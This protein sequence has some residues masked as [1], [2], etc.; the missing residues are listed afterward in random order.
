MDSS[1]AMGGAALDGPSEIRRG[2]EDREDHPILRDDEVVDHRGIGRFEGFGARQLPLRIDDLVGHSRIPEATDAVSEEEHLAVLGVDL[3]MRGHRTHEL[4]AEIECPARFERAPGEFERRIAFFECEQSIA[5]PDDIGVGDVVGRT[6]SERIAR[7]RIAEGS[8]ERP[9]MLA[10]E[11]PLVGS[12]PAIAIGDASTFDLEGVDHAVAGKEMV[13][14][15]WRKERVGAVAHERP[16]EF[17]RPVPLDLEIGSITF[18][19]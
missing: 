18:A 5:M 11:L 8:E 16:A 1:Q 17:V 14:I 13:G 12:H 19:A 10:L 7:N 2:G 3:R 9:A 15:P 4:A 6:G